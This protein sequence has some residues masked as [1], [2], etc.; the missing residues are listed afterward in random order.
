MKNQEYCYWC[1]AP[2]TSREHVPPKCFFP[3]R[4]DFRDFTEK[5]FRKNLITVPSCDLHNLSKSNDD[6]YLMV[7]LASR[8]GNNA[9]AFLHTK[10]KVRRSRERKPTM[11]DVLEAG[12]IETEHATFP[13]QMVHVDNLRLNHSFEAIGRA[14]FFHEFGVKFDGQCQIVSRIFSHPDAIQSTQFNVRACEMI[15]SEMRHWKTEIK[16]DNPEIFAYQFSPED[17]FKIRTL[18]L[19]FYENTQVFVILAQR[20]DE[21][22][23]NRRNLFKPIA[24][25]LFADILSSE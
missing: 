14:L 17:S 6:E 9:Q 4:K 20:P 2:S 22:L 7:C 16:G 25:S 11:V 21:E 10:T 13:V 5:D 12:I 19:T 3:E 8:V 18:C 1:G 23:E 15:E 24:E